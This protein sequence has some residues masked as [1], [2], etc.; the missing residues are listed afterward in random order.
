M[1]F[2]GIFSP[3]SERDKTTPQAAVIH[4]SVPFPVISTPAPVIHF[5][6]LRPAPIT[7]AAAPTLLLDIRRGVLLP[8]ATGIPLSAITP[9][10]RT[11]P[12]TTIHSSAIRRT[13]SGVSV[14]PMRRHSAIS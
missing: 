11:P 9:V 5:L 3:E 2:H 1:P 10:G 13:R 14:S 7:R 4:F 6:A 12:K 8:A